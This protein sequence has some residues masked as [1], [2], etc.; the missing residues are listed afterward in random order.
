V[1]TPDSG[2]YFRVISE[3]NVTGMFT[4]PTAIRAIIQTDP[5]AKLAKNYSFDQQVAFY[6]P[7]FVLNLNN[8]LMFRCVWLS[9]RNIFLAG[10]HCDHET[11]NWIKNVIGKP[12]FDHWW[13]TGNRQN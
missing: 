8:K 12:G 9:L 10:E 1:G 13:Q 5:K 6:F 7:A 11:M 2:A 4:A 3:H